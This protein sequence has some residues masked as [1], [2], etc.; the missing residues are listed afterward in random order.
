MSDHPSILPPNRTNAEAAIEQALHLG[1]PDLSAVS[2]LM[3]P[4]TC[5]AETLAW[6][7]WSFS[8]DGYGSNWTEAQRRRA[9]R[10]SPAMHRVKG[11]RGSVHRALKAA[12]FETDIFEWFET[13]DAPYTF[14]I[15]AFGEDIFDAGAGINSRLLNRINRMI[16]DVKPARAHYTLR[17]G[18]SFNINATAKAG[19]LQRQ[20]HRGQLSPQ[21]RP[22]DLAVAPTLKTGLRAR[23][24]QVLDLSPQPRTHEASAATT[25]KAG[26]R[27][28]TRHKMVLE[29]TPRQGA[30]YAK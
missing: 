4:D 19:V 23:Q 12:G 5:P 22:H 28:R 8:V 16:E 13:G 10:I 29:V 1:K 27:T 17:V 11:T 3:H 14:R 26:M 6:L 30:A 18:E 2:T 7:A 15:D 25:A 20:R 21:P 9:V 24:R